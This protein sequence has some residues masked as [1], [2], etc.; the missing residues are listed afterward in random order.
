MATEETRFALSGAVG[1]CSAVFSIALSRLLLAQAQQLSE[2]CSEAWNF[3]LVLL[4][5]KYSPAGIG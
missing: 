5:E 4:R 1:I 3:I 2:R